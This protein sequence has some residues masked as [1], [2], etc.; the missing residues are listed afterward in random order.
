MSE[1]QANFKSIGAIQRAN[2]KSGGCWFSPDTM[3]FFR[4]RTYPGVYGGRFFIS[5]EKQTGCFT[6]NTHPRLF[7][8]RE[9]DVE[10]DIGTVGEFQEFRTLKKAQARAEELAA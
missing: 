6:G 2:E 1:A 7:T 3:A 8:I 4:S 10:G 5:S 9:V